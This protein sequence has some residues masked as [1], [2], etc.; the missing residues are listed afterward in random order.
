MRPSPLRSVGRE[1]LIFLGFCLLT[2]ILN[3]RYKLRAADHQKPLMAFRGKRLCID[4]LFN[5]VL[6]G[7]IYTPNLFQSTFT[8]L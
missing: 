7:E 2:S 1:I 4:E 8:H 5:D 6:P 3:Q